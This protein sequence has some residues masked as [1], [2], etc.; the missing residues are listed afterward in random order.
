MMGKEFGLGGETGWPLGVRVYAYKFIHQAMCENTPHTHT[1]VTKSSIPLCQREEEKW[2]EEDA[3]VLPT[4]K[5]LTTSQSSSCTHTHAHASLSPCLN[6]DRSLTLTSP[7]Y[8]PL[9][10]DLH[11]SLSFYSGCLTNTPSILGMMD[12]GSDHSSSSVSYALI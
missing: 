9:P 3:C 5:R 4:R 7:F 12:D 2:Y 1:Q 8:H 10:W 6:F 11:P